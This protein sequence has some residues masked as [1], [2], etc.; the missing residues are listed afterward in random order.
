MAIQSEADHAKR[1]AKA[2]IVEFLK[3]HKLD[4]ILP[5]GREHKSELGILLNAIDMLRDD[6][7]A[8]AREE[9]A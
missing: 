5:F 6:L 9:Q 2:D 8:W 1:R 7:L 4:N 3:G